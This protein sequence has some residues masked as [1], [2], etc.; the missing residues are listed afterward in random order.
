MEQQ[1]YLGVLLQYPDKSSQVVPIGTVP[2]E[3]ARYMTTTGL[4]FPQYQLVLQNKPVDTLI[5]QVQN[6]TLSGEEKTESLPTI[7]NE[8]S[9]YETAM[10]VAKKAPSWAP[11][12]QKSQEELKVISEVINLR[13]PI[14]GHFFPYKI[15]LFK[16]FEHTPLNKVRVVI[17]G[18]DPYPTMLANG[19]PRA[20]GSAFSVA[21]DDETPMSQT[22]MFKE[23]KNSYPEWTPPKHGNLF[24]W[25][26]Q[27]VL[28]LNICLTCPPGASN[29]HCKYGVWMPFNYKV[30]EAISAT[31]PNCIYALWG[32]DAQKIQKYLG[33][34]AVVL[35][36]SHPVAR[37]PHNTFLGCG[38]FKKINDLLVAKGEQ[39]I[40][41]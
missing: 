26:Q 24:K 16:A 35:T 8:M 18:M 23:I 7:T 37:H 20:Q 31:R 13:I 3:Y 28:L 10:I 39:P 38:H 27:G 32:K 5:Q 19:K 21:E 25:E 15:N 9:I 17:V 1:Q 30:I 36:A 12:F 40:A 22:N 34:K 33:D 6:L 41:W 14:E 29:G 2:Y 4:P 11:V